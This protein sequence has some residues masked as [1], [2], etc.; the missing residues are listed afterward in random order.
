MYSLGARHT[1]EGNI[2]CGKLH[3]SRD[4][5]VE[6]ET[7]KT[8]KEINHKLSI[9]NRAHILEDLENERVLHTEKRSS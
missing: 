5:H 3:R 4:H 2:I 1:K 9:I 7:S 8:Q 6:E